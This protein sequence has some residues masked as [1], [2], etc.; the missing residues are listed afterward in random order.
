MG[1]P[2]SNI[3]L[4]GMGFLLLLQGMGLLLLLKGM[5]MGMGVL[6]LLLQDMGVKLVAWE[7]LEDL[8]RGQMEPYAYSHSFLTLRL[9]HVY[10]GHFI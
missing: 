10:Y 6:L 9:S 7:F 8:E 3:R 5:G 1:Y 2:L 4:K